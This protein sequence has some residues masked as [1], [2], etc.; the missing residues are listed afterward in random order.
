MARTTS[1]MGRAGVRKRAGLEEV[2]IRVAGPSV[3]NPAAQLDRLDSET[4]KKELTGWQTAFEHLTALQKRFKSRQPVKPK[5]TRKAPSRGERDWRD[6]HHRRRATRVS[7]QKD[8]GTRGAPSTSGT[9]QDIDARSYDFVDDIL[10]PPYPFD[11]IASLFENSG[12]LRRNVDAMA[13]NID[14]FGYTFNPVLDFSHPDVNDHIRDLL[15]LQAVDEKN[16]DVADLDEVEAQIDELEPELADV[17][18][19]RRLWERVAMVEKHRLHAFFESLHPRNTFTRL[20][21]QTRENLELFGNAAWEILRERRDDVYSRIE[22]AYHVPFASMRSSGRTSGPTVRS[23]SSSARTRSPGRSSSS[24]A[25]SGATSASSARR[26][27]TSRS[28]ATRARSRA[29]AA[30]TT[31]AWRSSGLRRARTR[32]RRTSSFTSR[33]TR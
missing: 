30:A 18:K 25:T 26:R 31:R 24:S 1:T 4:E 21:I 15:F 8:D 20:R 29:R 5:Q 33:S 28:S 27:R 32:S 19:K 11:V 2:R 10:D 23:R 12:P 22:Q 13:A 6:D 9:D 17:K 16:V 7:V 14:G 3:E